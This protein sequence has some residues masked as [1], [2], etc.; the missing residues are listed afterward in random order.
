VNFADIVLRYG[1]RLEHRYGQRLLPGH[2]RAL[3]AIVDCRTAA[4]GQVLF[5]CP[6]CHN[7]QTRP[8]S[9]GHRLCPVCRNFETTRWLARQTAKLLPVR[10]YMVTVTLPGVLRPVAWCHQRQVYD[11]MFAAA[12]EAMRDLA[13]GRHGF[14]A[15]IAMT[16]VLHTHARN[17]DYHPHIHFV[18]PGGGI[19]R[20]DRVW[21][22]R[23]GRWLFPARALSKLFRGKLAD[24][25]R[26]A[27]LSVPS[28][29]YNH[30]LVAKIIA[31]G[32]GEP[33]LKYLSRYLYRGVIAEHNIISD[34]DGQVTFQYVESRSRQRRTRAL[35]GEQF[36]WLILQHVLPKGFQRVRSYGFLHHR[37]RKTLLLVQYALR[38][39]AE[40]T[41]A[42][43]R[44]T[45]SCPRCSTPMLPVAFIRPHYNCSTARSPPPR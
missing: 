25:L 38:V 7:V 33:A 26:S 12:V 45:V 42:P 6:R 18:V 30:D 23:A 15:D 21:K 3:E 16:G 19:D 10:Y 14:G 37:A 17:R 9:C 13:R 2:R 36:L 1:D 39:A 11:G 34:A 31:A 24:R 40:L 29:V 27:G 20:I 4:C 41:Q 5:D 43:Q 8:C 35:P 32:S 44:P 28:A 22:R